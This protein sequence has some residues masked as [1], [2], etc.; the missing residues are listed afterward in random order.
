MQHWAEMG[1][2][3][4]ILAGKFGNDSLFLTLSRYYPVVKDISVI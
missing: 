3:G 2:I 4:L 1:Y